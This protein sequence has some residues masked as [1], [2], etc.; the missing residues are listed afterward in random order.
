MKYLQRDSEFSQIEGYAWVNIR[1]GATVAGIAPRDWKRKRR[2]TPWFSLALFRPVH[3]HT[4]RTRFA[5]GIAG[6]EIGVRRHP[7]WVRTL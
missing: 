6:R 1:I 4:P 5:L 2:H 7:G 3:R